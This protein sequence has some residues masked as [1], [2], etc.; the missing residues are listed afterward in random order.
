[1]E[2]TFRD[3]LGNVADHFYGVGLTHLE[4]LNCFVEHSRIILLRLMEDP[5]SPWFDSIST[6]KKETLTH[7][8][9]KSLEETGTF[10]REKLG[11]DPK[12]W[13][14]GRLH[15]VQ[16]NHPLGQVK[17]LDRLFNLGP[18]EGGGNFE[19]VWQSSVMPGMDFELNG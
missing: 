11:P 1:M 13:R 16:F 7:V 8:L 9:E 5:D 12:G 14:W 10:L 3:D 4:P 19:T 18:Y 2:N 15:T 6:P 17:P